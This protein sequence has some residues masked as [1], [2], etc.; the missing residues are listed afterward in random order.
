M[1]ITIPVPYGSITLLIAIVL[2]LAV[3]KIL[4]V[5]RG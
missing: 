5:L 3:F 1:T 2:T 4:S